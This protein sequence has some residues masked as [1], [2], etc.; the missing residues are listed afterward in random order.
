M[1]VAYTNNGV[2]LCLACVD[3]FGLTDPNN[4]APEDV[5]LPVD[6]ALLKAN[7]AIYGR[8]LRCNSPVCGEQIVTN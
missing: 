5:F 6:L 7:E 8:A 3:R 4:R 2:L 1:T